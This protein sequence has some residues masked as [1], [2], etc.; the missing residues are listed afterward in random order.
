MEE[1]KMKRQITLEEISDGRLYGLN[2][3]VKAD[4]KGCTGC[5]ACC[6][7]MG[8]SIILTPLDI[9][10]LE[11]GLNLS[12]G[13]LMIDKI[14]LH[15]VDGLILPNLKMLSETERCA[16]LD[17]VGRCTIH[18][19]R[20]DICRLFPLG[21]F[22]EEQG[23]RYFLQVHECPKTDRAKIKVKKWLDIPDLK[24][25]ER[26]IQD[27]HEYLNKKEAA[28][29]GAEE[30]LRKQVTMQLLKQFYIRPYDTNSDFYSQFYARMEEDESI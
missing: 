7:G 30:E 9:Y 15:V 29:E 3:M 28:L 10:R 6:Q 17:P 1:E 21:R 5:S 24:Q 19:C 4:C 11:Q 16:F 25:H 27:W 2:D 8:E 20:P 26:F 13:E 14:E 22:Y 18:A 23:F 12:F